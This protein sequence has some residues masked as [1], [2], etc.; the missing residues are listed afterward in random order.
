MTRT[1]IIFVKQKCEASPKSKADR[2]RS[3]KVGAESA[4][5]KMQMLCCGSKSHV[6]LRGASARDC[7]PCNDPNWPYDHGV[8]IDYYYRRPSVSST[9]GHFTSS[10]E[11]AAFSR[12]DEWKTPIAHPGGQ[13]TV[14]E[15]STIRVHVCWSNYVCS[16]DSHVTAVVKIPNSSRLNGKGSS[17]GDRKE[18]T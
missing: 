7:E 6:C 5:G 8:N 17:Y 11:S 14:L 16:D 9:E 4:P 15:A 3:S 2:G 12:E 1:Y 13:S 10:C 18:Q